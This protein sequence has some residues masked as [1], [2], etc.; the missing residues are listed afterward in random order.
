MKEN[1]MILINGSQAIVFIYGF[2]MLSVTQT[3]AIMTHTY[4]I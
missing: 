4:K 2:M 1:S 3:I